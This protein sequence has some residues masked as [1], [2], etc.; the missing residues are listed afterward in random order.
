MLFFVVVMFAYSS[1]LRSAEMLTL[2][3]EEN[4]Q[5]SLHASVN[6]QFLKKTVL[7]STGQSKNTYTLQKQPIFIQMPRQIVGYCSVSV[8]CCGALWSM[9][10]T[11]VMI[12]RA[13]ITAESFDFVG[14]PC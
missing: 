5:L 1:A 8:S 6:L 7:H 12:P 14:L 13:Y 11:V 2:L 4:S 3:Y 9:F 10:L